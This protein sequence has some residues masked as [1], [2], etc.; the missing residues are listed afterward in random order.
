M[1]ILN[2]AC[3]LDEV[4]A[5]L[6][7]QRDLYLLPEDRVLFVLDE[8]YYDLPIPHLFT[9]WPYDVVRIPLVER[10]GMEYEVDEALLADKTL[11]W[12]IT[13]L[14]V[15]HAST[16]RRIR[17]E[18]GIFTI[19]NPGITPDW[20]AILKAEYREQCQSTAERI[21]E[22][23]GGDVGGMMHVS[24]PDGIDLNLLLPAR[25]W[26]I[27]AGTREGSMTNG[28]FGELC[29]VPYWADGVLILEAGD[30]LTNPINRLTD[31][32]ELV[33]EDNV[34]VEIKGGEEAERLRKLLEAAQD[35]RAFRL[36]EFSFGLNP[37]LPDRLYCSTVAEKLLGGVHVAMGT[38]L[39]V[40]PRSPH[41]SR[42][43]E[44][45]YSAGVHIDAIKLRV[46]A[47][48]LGDLLKDGAL[49]V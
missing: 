43:T 12:L 31:R 37:G 7:A 22:A 11:A 17:K 30:F 49:A 39:S 32:V 38:P 4:V 33:V 2:R 40:N 41:F 35:P 45:G 21:L 34:V 29:N 9:T 3:T 46:S 36:G 23:M 10:P 16:S 48:F 13:S 1:S 28:V 20:P 15:S 27:E 5:V 18:L 25:N 14:S 24:S 6:E 26:K 44:V 42:F 8:A 19:S 47:R